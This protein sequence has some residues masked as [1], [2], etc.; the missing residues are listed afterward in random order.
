MT[1]LNML[2]QGDVAGLVSMVVVIGLLIFTVIRISSSMDVK[3]KDAQPGQSGTEAV[4]HYTGS[5]IAG[6]YSNTDRLKAVTA[7]ITAAVTEYRKNNPS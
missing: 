2:E 3:S 1:I 5:S 6:Q 7:A 4:T